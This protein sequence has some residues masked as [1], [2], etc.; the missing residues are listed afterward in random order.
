[1]G[2]FLVGV[3]GWIGDGGVHYVTNTSKGQVGRLAGGILIAHTLFL[4]RYGNLDQRGNPVGSWLTEYGLHG[5][6]GGPK[7][8]IGTVV[9]HYFSSLHERTVRGTLVTDGLSRKGRGFAKFGPICLLRNA[10]FRLACLDGALSG[11]SRFSSPRELSPP[12]SSL[13]SRPFPK[14]DKFTVPSGCHRLRT[15]VWTQDKT[16]KNATEHSRKTF[17]TAIHDSVTTHARSGRWPIRVGFVF[18]PF[19]ACLCSTLCALAMPHTSY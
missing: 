14:S 12:A 2:N 11:W 18:L 16:K 17:T 9:L 13:R 7:N 5:N 19:F 15:L 4:S 3:L 8:P 10:R 1:M 6:T